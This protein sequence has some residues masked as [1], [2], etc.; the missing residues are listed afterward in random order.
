M[1]V[2]FLWSRS[3]RFNVSPLIQFN[4]AWWRVAIIA[5]DRIAKGEEKCK[6]AREKKKKS[7]FY[8][9]PD[10]LGVPCSWW[11]RGPFVYHTVRHRDVEYPLKRSG[12]EIGALW[13]FCLL[14]KLVKY[15]WCATSSARPPSRSAVS[16]HKSSPTFATA[17]AP[18]TELWNYSNI[19]AFW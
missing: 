13:F 12:E 7:S 4:S 1:F 3:Y 17:I 19:S 14:R 2:W 10:A 9:T 15:G 11:Y 8:L 16:C 6:N 18:V 5:K